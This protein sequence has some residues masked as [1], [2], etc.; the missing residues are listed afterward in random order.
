MWVG[1]YEVGLVGVCVWVY[2]RVGGQ[3]RVSQLFFGLLN[4][5]LRATPGTPASY[6]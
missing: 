2:G 3:H 1:E 4:C 6:L 5:V